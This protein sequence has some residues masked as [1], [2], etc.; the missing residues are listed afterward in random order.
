MDGTIC[1]LRSK[2]KI[3][4]VSPAVGNLDKN[5]TMFF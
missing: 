2:G 5:E 1:T 4:Q 3:P